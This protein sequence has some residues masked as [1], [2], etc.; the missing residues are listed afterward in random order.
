MCVRERKRGREGEGERVEE[1]GE[2][3]EGGKN[4]RERRERSSKQMG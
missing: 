4:A 2:V 1:G 3:R